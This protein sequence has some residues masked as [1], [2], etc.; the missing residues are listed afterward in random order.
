MGIGILLSIARHAPVRKNSER[1]KKSK[2]EIDAGEN[3][4]AARAT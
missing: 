2:P 1:E 4:F 3:P